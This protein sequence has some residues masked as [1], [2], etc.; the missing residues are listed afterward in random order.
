MSAR[1]LFLGPKPAR[2]ALAQAWLPLGTRRCAVRVLALVARAVHYAHTKGI[3]HRDL[4]PGNILLSR[5]GGSE[6]QPFVTDFGLALRL[7]RDSRL[8]ATGAVMGTGHRPRSSSQIPVRSASAPGSKREVSF[9][10]CN[11]S[12]PT[13]PRERGLL[14]GIYNKRGA[15]P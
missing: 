14:R 4:K 8:T 11:A 15:G 7:D 10:I 6:E 5:E 2:A 13:Q 9:P 1:S 3:L 12:S